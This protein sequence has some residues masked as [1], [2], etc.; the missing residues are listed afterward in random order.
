MNIMTYCMPVSISPKLWAL[1]LYKGTLTETYFVKNEKRGILQLLTKD[2]ESLI[3]ILGKQSGRDIDKARECAKH[4]W[5]WKTMNVQWP[6]STADDNDKKKKTNDQECSYTQEV[7]PQCGLYLQLQAVEDSSSSSSSIVM[8][9]GD[10]V[11]VL[12]QVVNTGEWSSSNG[13]ICWKANDDTP[14]APIDGIQDN[15]MYSGW[16]RRQE[17]IL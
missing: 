10:H 7:L 14:M 16:L 3:P 12:C 8:D 4:G 15:V 9:A 2:H 6:S 17:G 5:E 1:S 11:V 13:G